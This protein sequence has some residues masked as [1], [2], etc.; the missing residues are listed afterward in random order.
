VLLPIQP[1]NQLGFMFFGCGSLAGAT[2]LFHLIIHGFYKSFS[3]LSAA[4]ELHD[5]ED[6]Q[7]GEFDY[8]DSTATFSYYDLLTSLVFVSINAIPLPHLPFQRSL[9]CFQV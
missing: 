9:C 3:F 8:L 4:T 7:D 2:V 1:L 6:E 5:L